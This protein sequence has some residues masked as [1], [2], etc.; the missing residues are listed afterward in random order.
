MEKDELSKLAA[1]IARIV[2]ENG[3]VDGE[4][5]WWLLSLGAYLDPKQ[6]K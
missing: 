1:E 6:A 3:R 4:G 5:E 2:I